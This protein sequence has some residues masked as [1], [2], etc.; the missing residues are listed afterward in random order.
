METLFFY[1]TVKLHFLKL[2]ICI[3]HTL[4]LLLDCESEDF[5]LTLW[6]WRIPLV[7]LSIAFTN[8]EVML[9]L[10]AGPRA[11]EADAL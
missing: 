1:L 3:F 4:L 5:F 11:Y 2:D 6:C 9:G 7:L 8:M 10:N